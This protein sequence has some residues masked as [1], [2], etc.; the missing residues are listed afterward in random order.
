MISSQ[1]MA[2][3]PAAIKKSYNNIFVKQQLSLIRAASHRCIKMLS[4]FC[5]GERAA[6]PVA[7]ILT[8]ATP[9]DA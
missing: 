4:F 8:L 9:P 7:A 3:P 2:A 5:F 6:P 1:M